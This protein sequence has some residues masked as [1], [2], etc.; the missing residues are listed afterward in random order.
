MKIFAFCLCW[1]LILTAPGV[2]AQQTAPPNQSWDVLRQLQSGEKLRVERKIG[3]KKVS[4]KFVSLS[5]TELVIERKR[6]NVS[7][8]RDEVKRIW[9]VD[10]PNPTKRVLST[11][12]GGSTGFT[13]GFLLGLL[14]VAGGD[15]GGDCGPGETGLI[16]A[17]VA[18]SAVGALLGHFMVESKR[19]LIY[20]AP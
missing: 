13:F 15:C 19:T 11:M 4:G 6:K 3:K 5:D 18:A 8:S 16:G 17:T 1:L 10:P 9:Q 7:F 12:S 2:M 20:V 14:F